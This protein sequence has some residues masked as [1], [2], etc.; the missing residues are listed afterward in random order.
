ML[1]NCYLHA[2]EVSKNGIQYAIIS[3]GFVSVMTDQQV[4]D[5]NTRMLYA[6]LATIVPYSTQQM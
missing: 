4:T 5:K 2:H 1:I 6:C 3:S